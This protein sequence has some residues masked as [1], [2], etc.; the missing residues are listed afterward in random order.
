MIL[1]PKIGYFKSIASLSGF[2]PI[3]V[4]MNQ[5]EIPWTLNYVS[6]TKKYTVDNQFEMANKERRKS[7]ITNI[8]FCCIWKI[9]ICHVH[10]FEMPTGIKATNTESFSAD[11]HKSLN[12]WLLNDSTTRWFLEKSVLAVRVGLNQMK[13]ALIPP[14]LWKS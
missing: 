7:F 12:W 10:S 13:K 2:Y 14:Y 11:Y 5:G 4:W 1:I 3:Y 6:E 8:N 9:I